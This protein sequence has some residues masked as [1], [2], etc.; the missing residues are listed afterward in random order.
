[1]NKPM[2]RRSYL[3]K[4][5]EKETIQ[6]N[7]PLSFDEAVRLFLLDLRAKNLSVRKL[8]FH[9]T[10]LYSLQK[11]LMCFLSSKITPK[12]RVFLPI[13]VMGIFYRCFISACFIL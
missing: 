1:M 8:E 10:N 3:L 11:A 13:I 5:N 6:P 7:I 9:E 2:K 12:N 4:R